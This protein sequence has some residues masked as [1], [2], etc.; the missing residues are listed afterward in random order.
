MKVVTALRKKN[1]E[2][3]AVKREGP[4]KVP[5]KLLPM[6]P[7]YFKQLNDEEGCRKVESTLICPVAASYMQRC[8]SSK[9]KGHLWTSKQDVIKSCV[10]VDSRLH[11]LL[12][13]NDVTTH[14]PMPQLQ[15][16]FSEG[17]GLQKLCPKSTSLRALLTSCLHLLLWSNYLSSKP[18]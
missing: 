13:R 17:C 4:G 15:D 7:C 5:H 10:R 14:L 8:S 2:P 18:N 9:R 6:L 12:S 3:V 1:E 11:T 16:A